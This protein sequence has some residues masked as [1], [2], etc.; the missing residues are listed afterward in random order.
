MYIKQSRNPSVR[1]SVCPIRLV[2]ARYALPIELPAAEEGISF[3]RAIYIVSTPLN[4]RRLDVM[5]RHSAFDQIQTLLLIP[6]RH[7]FA[8]SKK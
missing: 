8:K 7:W 4:V 6:R 3:H 1:R 5:N 2:V